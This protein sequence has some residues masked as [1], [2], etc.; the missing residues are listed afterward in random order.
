MTI[1]RDKR[2]GPSTQ[3]GYV[4]IPHYMNVYWITDKQNASF[5]IIQEDSYKKYSVSANI[6]QSQRKQTFGFQGGQ[7]TTETRQLID[8]THLR[9]V[10]TVSMHISNLDNVHQIKA[11]TSVAENETPY[12]ET[13]IPVSLTVRQTMQDKGLI[14]FYFFKANK[15]GSVRKGRLVNVLPVLKDSNVWLNITLVNKD[16]LSLGSFKLHVHDPGKI[17]D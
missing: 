3:L 16:D 7:L 14:G 8:I 1:P 10:P 17:Y 5:L 13:T 4:E 12:E 15:R 11:D 9:L 2:K 6:P